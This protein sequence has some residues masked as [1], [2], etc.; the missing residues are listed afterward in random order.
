[1][2]LTRDENFE[3]DPVVHRIKTWY[4]GPSSPWPSILISASAPSPSRSSEWKS[5]SAVS[6]EKAVPS[7][8]QW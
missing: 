2:L 7:E 3:P 8:M 5:A 6:T 4:W 1:M